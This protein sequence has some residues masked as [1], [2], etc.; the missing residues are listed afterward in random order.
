MLVHCRP[1][2]LRMAALGF[3]WADVTATQVYTIF[4]IHL[5]L[6]DEFVC[7]GAIPRSPRRLKVTGL[8][9]LRSFGVIC[10]S[11]VRDSLRAFRTLPGTPPFMTQSDFRASIKCLGT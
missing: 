3:G 2:E 8:R 5:L 1:E 10:A 6:A 7:R 11:A 4:D 9:R